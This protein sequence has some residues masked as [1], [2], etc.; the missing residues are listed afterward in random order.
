MNLGSKNL[1]T[2]ETLI[3]NY[4]IGF[5]NKMNRINKNICLKWSMGFMAILMLTFSSCQKDTDAGTGTGDAKVMVQMDGVSFEQDNYD[6]GAKSSA[7]NS[8]ASG[9]VKDTSIVYDDFVVD[10]QMTNETDRSSRTV[11]NN[12][13]YRAGNSNMAA[14]TTVTTKLAPGIKYKLVAFNSDGTLNQTKEYTVGR[15]ATTGPMSLDAGKN[16]TFVAYSFNGTTTLPDVSFK[17]TVKTFANAILPTVDKDLMVFVAKNRAISHGDTKL[18]IVL[19]HRFSM[20][21]TKLT[22]DAKMTGSI[23]S[24]VNTTF[25]PTH[26][27]ATFNFTDE[28]LTYGG[29]LTSRPSVAWP[30][31]AVGLREVISTPTLLIA[32][33][34]SNKTLVFGSIMIDD[35]TKTNF[36]INNIRVNP[37]CKYNLNLNFRTCTEPVNLANDAMNWSY[38][39]NGSYTGCIT[40]S[41]EVKNGTLLSHT[42][43]APAS[44]YGFTFDMTELDN[45]IN[46]EVNGTRIFTDP[47][48]AI[49]E[50]SQ[51]QF[52]TYDNTANGEGIITRNIMF[53]G[54]DEYGLDRNGDKIHDVPEIWL[55]K[56]TATKPMIRIS[57][58]KTGEVAMLGSK[59]SGGDLVQLILKNNMKFNTVPWNST[60]PNVVKITQRVSN[61]TVVIGKGYGQRKIA[62]PTT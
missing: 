12:T 5:K 31:L 61:K 34:A 55:I 42:F 44:N 40:P 11:N 35:E 52:Q 9:I 28:T 37:G 47:A 59:T 27:N 13:V 3:G 62:C 50:N 36:T 33:M 21:T 43:N 46:V 7:A 56:G 19:K 1:M 60:S 17:T 18:A 20:I 2:V 6:Y 53:V 8:S 25:G 51:I 15:E 24:L 39:V 49:K 14:S 23:K 45:A 38:P 10:V 4:K 22:M 16:Y 57:I 32:P 30:N 58:S 29:T 26:A 48:L 41:G 54:G